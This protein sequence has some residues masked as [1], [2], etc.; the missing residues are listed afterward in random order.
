[1]TGGIMKHQNRSRQMKRNRF[2]ILSDRGTANGCQCFT[3]IELLVVIAIIAILAVA[4][5]ESGAG[6]GKW[7][8]LSEQLQTDGDGI[9]PIFTGQ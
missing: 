3:L 6:T 7:N 1:M 5:F 9:L 2:S 8:Q 4:R